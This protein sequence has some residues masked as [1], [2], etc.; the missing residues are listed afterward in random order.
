MNIL[1]V[2]AMYPP[3]RTGTSFYSK[4]VNNALKMRGHDVTVVTVKMDD[5]NRNA[6]GDEIRLSSIHFNI[7][8]FFKHF[9]ISSFVPRNYF[10]I[11][12]TVKEKKPDVILLVNHYLDI[13]F[14]AVFASIVYKI[15]LV[16]SVGTQ[17]QS[18]NPVR[19]K[20]LN[21]FD[22]LI[23]GFLV[24]PFTEK[25]ISW[26]KEIE[27]YINTVHRRRFKDKSVIIPF[28][29]NGDIEVYKKH[30]HSYDLHNQIIGVGAVIDHRNYKFQVELFNRIKAG[31]PDMKLKIIGHVY[32]DEAARLA[33]KYGLENSVSFLGEQPHE[34]VLNEM[35]KSDLHWMMLD[36]EYKGIGTS[37]LEAM[38][39]GVPVIL[40]IPDNLFGKGTL[41]DMS[42]F[43]YTDGISID[44]IE[45]KII[46]LLNDK[47]MRESIGSSGKIFVEKYMNWDSVALKM[48]ELFLSIAKNK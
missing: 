25:I 42:D 36:G 46:K 9:R 41:K 47:K 11:S 27:R 14:L 28:G 8:N 5:E 48:E 37:N 32:N 16:I 43:I 4:N 12:K 24:F 22:Y 13:A 30:R 2:S 26:D 10:R 34:V 40:N 21:I 7:K 19:N 45:D 31:F 38:L 6:S 1:L 44:P 39:L 33:E 3:V 35:M 23:C 20:I 29:V 17:L 18:V 15:P